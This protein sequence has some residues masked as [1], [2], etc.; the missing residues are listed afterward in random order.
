MGYFQIEWFIYL[1]RLISQLKNICNFKMDLKR[2]QSLLRGNHLAF[3]YLVWS[4]LGKS[5][6]IF[7]KKITIIQ[8]YSNRV[9]FEPWRN[10]TSAFFYNKNT[11]IVFDVF[12]KR[13][14]CTIRNLPSVVWK[15]GIYLFFHIFIYTHKR[16]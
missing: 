2:S 5:S 10:P 4:F 9:Y 1:Y 11:Y 8:R 12:P 3:S 15:S 14:S 7:N 16:S 13:T 6:S